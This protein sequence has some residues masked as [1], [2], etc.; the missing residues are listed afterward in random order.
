MALFQQKVQ[1]KLSL[2]TVRCTSKR[3]VVCVLFLYLVQRDRRSLKSIIKIFVCL[4]YYYYFLNIVRL[5]QQYHIV[6]SEWDC[7]HVWE[8]ACFCLASVC[9]ITFSEIAIYLYLNVTV[10]HM[11]TCLLVPIIKGIAT[12]QHLSFKAQLWDFQGV[13]LPPQGKGFA[14]VYHSITA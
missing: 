3:F 12:D 11:I 5:S 13:L 6:L 14:N 1:E 4:C 9:Y 7:K 2:R 10:F 8:L